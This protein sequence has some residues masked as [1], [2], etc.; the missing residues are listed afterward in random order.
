M[1]QLL[2]FV[3]KVMCGAPIAEEVERGEGGTSAAEAD[4]DDDGEL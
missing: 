1:P 3:V 4:N 2:N